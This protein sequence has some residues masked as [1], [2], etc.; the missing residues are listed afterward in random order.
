LHD[1]MNHR[2]GEKLFQ[3]LILDLVHG[4]L[5]PLCPLARNDTQMSM[6]QKRPQCDVPA[7]CG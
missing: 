6:E 3:R 1:K 4:R 2:I 5:L 7:L